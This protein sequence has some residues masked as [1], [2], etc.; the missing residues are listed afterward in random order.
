MRYLLAIIL[1]TCT[2]IGKAQNFNTLYKD[3]LK[4]IEAEEFGQAA[5]I[6]G[7]AL[8]LADKQDK[9][10]TL[11]NLAYSQL[12]TGEADKAVESYNKAIEIKP[13]EKA[14]LFQRA[15]TYMQA[16]DFDKA[17]EDCDSI[18]GHEPDNRDALLLRAQAYIQKGGYDKAKEGFVHVITL[19]PGNMSAKL[20]LVQV[21]QKKEM[22]NEAL[23][24]IGLLID[25]EPQ[26]P[27]LYIV[28]SDVER[29]MGLYELALLDNK[30]AIRL[31]PD[32]AGYYMLRAILYEKLGNSKEAGKCRNK[33]TSIKARHSSLHDFQKLS[34]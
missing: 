9:F 31:C 27:T 13:G 4:F 15:N 28:R 1:A 23:A 5:S 7:Q 8:S 19:E 2:F 18:I 11:V 14:L 16:G 21:Y 20:G 24:L 32:N 25:E 22:F 10:K 12:M 30:E 33:A 29:E 26:S 3:G 34:L 6:L 17:I